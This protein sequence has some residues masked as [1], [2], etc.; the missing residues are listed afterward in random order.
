MTEADIPQT[1]ELMKQLAIF[2]HYID[3]FVI[4]PEIVK[5]K[6]INQ[7]DFYCL[8]VDDKES[9]NIAFGFAIKK[10]NVDL[11]A[12]LDKGLTAIKANGTYQAIMKNGINSNNETF[13][14][15]GL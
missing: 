3:V 15:L 9:G 8:V 7:P 4:T 14:K 5:E 12:K 6:A 2:E 1:F 10:G 13:E 11:K